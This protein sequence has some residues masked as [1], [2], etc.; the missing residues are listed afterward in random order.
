M[1]SKT[2]DKTTKQNDASRINTVFGYFRRL[3]FFC[4]ILCIIA[5]TGCAGATEPVSGQSFYFDTVCQITIYAMEDMNEEKADD[6]IGDAFALCKDYERLFSRTIEGTDIDRI[7]RAEGAWVTVSDETIDIIRKGLEFNALSGGRFALTIG[8]VSGLWDFHK[9]DGEVPDADKL[10]EAVMHVG[11]ETIEIDGNKVRLTDPETRIDLGAIAKGYVADRITEELETK[12]VTSAMIDL[13]GNLS[14][15]GENA[16][17]K[18][19]FSVGIELPF[20]DRREIAATT[21]L[22]DS[23]IVTSGVYQRF[24]KDGDA[25]Y[26]HVLDPSTGYPVK[27]DLLGVSVKGAK[28]HSADCDALS[29]IC[30]LLGKEEGLRLINNLD[31]FEALFIDEEGEITRTDGFS[32]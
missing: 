7:N 4:V 14:C 30:M 13:G 23:T 32:E 24:I 29:T 5:Q 3:C 11:D 15:I 19:A 27:T 16:S 10:R 17:R 6:A 31:G 18:A 8:G 1:K 28:G 20:S 2:L 22:A 26:H 12:G 21:S 9:E 25:L